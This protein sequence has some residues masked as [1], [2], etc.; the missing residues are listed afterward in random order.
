MSLEAWVTAILLVTMLAAL[1]TGKI[2]A[3][4]VVVGTL[5]LLILTGIVEPVEAVRNFA[6]PAVITIAFL[7]VV[8]EGLKETGAINVLTARLLGNPRTPLQAQARLV[9]PVAALSAVANNT[10]IVATFMPVIS[11]L[12]KR[13]GL[14]G[15]RLFMPLSFAAILGGLCTLIGTSTTLVVAGQ[16]RAHNKDI[17]EQRDAIVL[18]NGGTADLPAAAQER[19]D[20]LPPTMQEFSM[21]TIAGAGAPVAVIGIA[22][23]LLFG[24]RLLPRRIDEGLAH[25][26][27][28]QYVVAMRVRSDSVI[29]GKTI[30]QAELR[31]LPGLF[32]SR[33]ERADQTI[34][35]VGPDVQFEPNDILLFVG[36]LSSVVDLQKIKGLTPITD[37]NDKPVDYRPRMKLTEVV[38][39]NSSPLIGRTIRD[40]GIRTRYNA[41]VVA[42]HRQGHRQLG[43]IGDIVVRP[44]DTLL[45]ETGK[46]FA[47]R[48]RESDEFILVSELEG[49]AAPRHERAWVA[50]G[51][52]LVVVLTISFE[53][54][55]P[56][57]AAMCGAAL[58]VLLRCCTGPQARA[59][60]DFQVLTVIGA[61]FGVG[62]AMEKSGLASFI[63]HNGIAWAAELGPVVMLAIIYFMTVAFTT[64]ITNNA[65]AVLM[66]PIA[67]EAAHEASLNPLPFAVAVAIAASAEFSTPIGYQTNLMVM[68]PGGYKWID[69]LR[70]GGPLTLLSGAI[71]IIFCTFMY[72]SLVP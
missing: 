51:I 49:S 68:G 45:L 41:V 18:A 65:A 11:S 19:I 55:D 35:A 4:L 25:N 14:A 70:F 54:L 43:K 16:V 23:I 17:H 15:T 66:I 63:A 31:N 5:F 24:R 20:A 37:D 40:A 1:I 7:Y 2:G 27:A 12:T 33:I 64:C 42:V 21:F 60:V 36:R 67:F 47:R 53:I 50:M 52:L 61:A 39:S 22:Y 29:V 48:Y 72:G 32:L 59:S 26:Q 9:L 8:A 6:N 13:T 58:M 46:E 69:Y 30:E 10:P 38:I 3:D 71:A 62:A 28:R 57:V 34:L 56:M 44:G